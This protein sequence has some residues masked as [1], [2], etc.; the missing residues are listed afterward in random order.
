MSGKT[1]LLLEVVF[2]S[3]RWLNDFMAQALPKSE[4]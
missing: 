3:G 1:L 2:L 4:C